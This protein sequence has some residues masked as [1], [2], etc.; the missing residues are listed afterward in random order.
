MIR[1]MVVIF[2]FLNISSAFSEDRALKVVKDFHPSILDSIGDFFQD[3]FYSSREEV[4]EPSQRFNARAGKGP[5][6]ICYQMRYDRKKLTYK[7][8]NDVTLNLSRESYYE[9]NTAFKDCL[10]NNKFKCIRLYYVGDSFYCTDFSV[11]GGIRILDMNLNEKKPQKIKN[12]GLRPMIKKHKNKVFI[13]V[14]NSNSRQTGLTFGQGDLPKINLS[15]SLSHGKCELEVEN[16][17]QSQ[18]QE[19]I[20]NQ[21]KTH[22]VG[23][24]KIGNYK[25]FISGGDIDA[26]S[27]ISCDSITLTGETVKCHVGQNVKTI[28]FTKTCLDNSGETVLGNDNKAIQNSSRKPETKIY[29]DEQ[30]NKI[31]KNKEK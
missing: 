1:Y 28:R 12:C 2:T 19:K 7:L 20:F 9:G 30:L 13:S 3:E 31:N 16:R 29:T 6:D 11:E 27:D 5:G 26:E 23:V 10:I 4:F 18:K 14:G 24:A 15:R 17:L 22:I 8:P 25:C 21:A